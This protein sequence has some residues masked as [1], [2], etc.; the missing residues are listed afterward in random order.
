MKLLITILFS[1]IASSI[2]FSK[3]NSNI[4]FHDLHIHFILIISR[5]LCYRNFINNCFSTICVYLY[6]IDIQTLCF[7]I[8]CAYIYVYY[9]SLSL[10]HKLYSTFSGVV[11]RGVAVVGDGN[12]WGPQIPRS[13]IN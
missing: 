9:H 8:I 6:N 7:I 11:T 5:H 10:I 12:H 4:L 3:Y 1:I 13:S 2:C